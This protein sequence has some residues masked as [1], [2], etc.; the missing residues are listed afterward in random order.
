MLKVLV[1]DDEPKVRRG[2]SRL[3]GACPDKY[4]LLGSCSDAAEVVA[5]LERTVPDVIVTDIRMPNQDGLELIN[6]LKHRYHNLD[7]IILS[8]YGDFEYAK[9]ALQYQVFDF[10]LKPLRPDELYSAL[11]GV[12]E[13]RKKNHITETQS[14]EDNYFFNLIRT[15]DAEVEKKNL[16]SLGLYEKT[17]GYRV[18]ILDLGEIPGKYF[19]ETEVLKRTVREIFPET[20]QLYTCFRHQIVLVWEKELSEEAI[21]ASFEGLQKKLEGKIY[22]GVSERSESY[23]DFKRRYFQALDAVKQYIYSEETCVFFYEN[24]SKEK[25]ITFSDASCEKII[26]AVRAG[27]EELAEKLL[28]EFLNYYRKSRCTIL[29]LKRQLTLLQTYVASLTEELGIDQKCSRAMMDLVRNI[30]EIRSFDEVEEVFRHNFTEMA[31]EAGTLAERRMNS[32][33]MEQILA[34]VQENLG[35]DLSLS[36]VAEY[37]NLSVG[38]LSNYFKV[39]MGTN[40]TDYLTQLRIEKAKELLM[41]TNEKIYRV[42]ELVGYQNSQ[43]FVTMFKRRTGVTPAEYR[44][45]LTK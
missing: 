39:K 12:S 45:C 22:L 3:I 24:L 32:F 20:Q 43:Y 29:H 36:E 14:L 37:V 8:G 34:Y 30:E 10:L 40:F 27:N 11:D 33:Y 17:G 1:A 19:E 41:Y 25:K 26:N 4:E 7:F 18:A 13:K 2:V 35:R 23:S 31:K 16:Q 21:T 15:A 44:K 6:Y 9:K 28:T 42:A 38:Y 5:F